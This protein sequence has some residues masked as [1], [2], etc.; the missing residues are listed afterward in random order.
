MEMELEQKVY[1]VENLMMKISLLNIPKEVFFPVP[2]QD[3][4][5][6][7]ANSS[8]HSRLLLGWTESM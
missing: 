4:T 5:V 3:Q 2:I 7:D 6:M 1:T 8:L